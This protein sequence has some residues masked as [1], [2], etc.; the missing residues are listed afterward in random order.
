MLQRFLN[1]SMLI[2]LI[3]TACLIYACKNIEFDYN[4]EHFF[5]VESD[6]AAYYYNF[7]DKFESDNAFFL[8]GIDHEKSIFDSTFLNEIE[9]LRTDLK[10]LNY[11]ISA[12]A[13]TNIKTPVI[14]SFGIVE[15]PLVD[16]QHPENLQA[17]SSRIFSIPTFQGNLIS[18]NSKNLTIFIRH[19][20]LLPK[21]SADS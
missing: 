15:I 18:A 16:L 10:S 3:L 12:S 6:D 5:P 8:I 13:I 7:R 21:P 19:Q 20:D 4:F 1:V 9:H 2:L 17:D 11:V 14:N